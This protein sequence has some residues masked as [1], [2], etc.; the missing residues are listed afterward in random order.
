MHD[1]LSLYRI[2]VVRLLPAIILTFALATFTFAQDTIPPSQTQAPAGDAADTTPP[3]TPH[4]R[5]LISASKNTEEAW[6]IL[7]NGVHDSKHPEIR[8]Q[9]L[10]ALGSIGVNVR[11]AKL[12]IEALHDPDLDVRTAAILAAG[13][14]GNRSLTTNLRPLLNDKEPQVVVVAA[15]TL[16]KLRDHSGEDILLSVI[17]GERNPNP[18]IPTAAV[19]NLNKQIHSPSG[20]ARLGVQGASIFLGPVGY[21]LSAIDFMRKNGGDNAARL[22]AISQVSQQQS[23]TIRKTLIAA[24]GDKDAAIRAAAAKALGSYRDQTTSS[25]LLTALDDEKPGVRL[26]AAAAYIRARQPAQRP[27]AS[28]K[29]RSNTQ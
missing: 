6:T 5:S 11:S 27:A 23:D 19:R 4:D 7:T 18:S 14:T 8:I 22:T 28:N 25:A 26:F 21:G 29:A 1:G 3:P 2:S 15:S 12:I 10:S 9:A 24:L 16:W 17:D 20:L 13:E